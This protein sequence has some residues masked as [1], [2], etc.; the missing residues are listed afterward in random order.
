MLAPVWDIWIDVAPPSWNG[1]DLGRTVLRIR[2]DSEATVAVLEREEHRRFPDYCPE[3][4]TNYG[5]AFCLGRDK[6]LILSAAE[7]VLWW[8]DLHHYLL[9]QVIAEQTGRW[10]AAHALSHGIAADHELKAR[11]A[12]RALAAEADYEQVLDHEQNWL[13]KAV[14]D[15]DA[16]HTL[17]PGWRYLNA[18]ATLSCSN[19]K[20]RR[21]MITFV[22][23][24]RARRRGLEAFW[25]S[26]IDK[27]RRCCGSMA[28][29]PLRAPTPAPSAKPRPAAL[30][31]GPLSPSPS[32]S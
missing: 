29:C 25:K 15:A 14:D 5:G 4:H 19:R 31:V 18:P 21:V 22:A 12:A 13:S 11:E 20:W 2:R 23:A 16:D 26:E 6:R 3:R 17:P 10:P 28:V 9:F 7:A 1:L 27:R 24:E 32:R 30:R 8:R